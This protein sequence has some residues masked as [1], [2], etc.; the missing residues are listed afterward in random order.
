MF[1]N[2]IG[3]ALDLRP[4][5]IYKTIQVCFYLNLYVCPYV[6]LYVGLC[7]FNYTVHSCMLLFVQ[8]EI[9]TH[10]DMCNTM[11]ICILTHEYIHVYLQSLRFVKCSLIVSICQS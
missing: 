1:N 2:L 4:L 8:N 7:V 11:H 3:A 10:E 9:L 5:S 6:K